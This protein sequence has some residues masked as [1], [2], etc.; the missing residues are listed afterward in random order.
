M[1]IHLFALILLLITIYLCRT[2]LKH[3]KLTI[4]NKAELI[5]AIAAQTDLTKVEAKKALDAFIN[6]TSEALKNGERLTLV[7]F[8]T[9]SVSEREARNGRNPR[10]GEVIQIEAKKVVKFKAGAELD[11]IVN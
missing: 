5:S 9:F 4:M 8:G 10:T 2:E 1:L 11:D 7:G 3:P 6:V